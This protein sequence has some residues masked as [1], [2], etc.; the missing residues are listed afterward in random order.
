[1]LEKLIEDYLQARANYARCQE[2]GLQA[3]FA[4]EEMRLEAA[5][6]DLLDFIVGHSDTLI[7]WERQNALRLSPF[8]ES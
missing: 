6:R 1:M 5:K 8:D 4:V 7:A 2:E 3:L